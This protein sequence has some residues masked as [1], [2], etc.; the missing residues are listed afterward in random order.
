[1]PVSIPLTCDNQKPEPLQDL[2]DTSIIF[3][4]QLKSA[5]DHLGV[6]RQAVETAL[7]VAEVVAEVRPFLA[8]LLSLDLTSCS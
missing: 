1:M 4:K 5:L 3:T 6:G 7:T 8:L 2:I